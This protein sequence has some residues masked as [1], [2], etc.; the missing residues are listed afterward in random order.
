MGGHH[1]KVHVIRDFL[2]RQQPSVV[3]GR[4]AELSEE[5]LGVALT[6]RGDLATEIFD[7]E[8]ARR[9]ATVHLR[10]GDGAAHHG[11][12]GRDHVD[13]GAFDPLRVGAH[14]FA[15]EGGS[16]EVQSQSLDRWIETHIGRGAWPAGNARRNAL[17]EAFEIG[18]Q[19]A[20]LE[21]D[22]E[23][24]AVQPMFIEIHQH[25]AARE[26]PAKYSFPAMLRGKELGLIQQDEFIGPWTEQ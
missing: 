25:Q 26:Q 17:V 6:A 22:G 3:G 19:R 24:L 13:E 14:F 12:G 20:G 18:F 1:E 4:L 21:G 23:R 9:D 15:E 10:A 16:G 8:L 7:H 11:D 5:V 2:R